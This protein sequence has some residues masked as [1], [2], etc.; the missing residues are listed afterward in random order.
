MFRFLR[1]EK[2]EETDEILLERFQQK[3][4]AGALADLFDR[5]LEL[6]F[7]LCLQYLKSNERA[8]D[9]SM[10][11]YVELQE[12]LPKHE[13]RNFR[14]WLHTFVRNHCLMQL[15]REK[16]D[17]S[18]NFDPALMH[19]AEDWHPIEE[20]SVEDSRQPALDYCLGQLNEQQK[21][22][23]HLFYYE[24]HSYKEI[25]EQRQETVGKV[26]SN[27]QNGRRNLKLCIEEQQAR[28]RVI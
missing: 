6:I 27:I 1:G 25:A 10:A 13:V 14:S 4:E 21:A 16:K 20:E 5:Y 9:A 24:G 7:G 15:R 19:S 22:C 17:L 11:I 2:K 28:N 12:K 18:V 8:E 23:V 26:R 3:G